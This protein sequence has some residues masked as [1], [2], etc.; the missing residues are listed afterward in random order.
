MPRTDEDS[1]LI[2]EATGEA[3]HVPK[4][5]KYETPDDLARKKYA[6]EKRKE[7]EEAHRLANELKNKT[8]GEFFWSLYDVGAAYHPEMSDG[9]L[10]KVIYLLTFLDYKRNILVSRQ[11][12]SDKYRPMTKDDVRNVIRL[13]RCKFPKFWDDLMSTGIIYEN[14]SGELEVDE[15]FRRGH[16]DKRELKDI[17]RIKLFTYAIRYMYENTDVR[18]HRYLAY[19]YRLIPYINLKYNVLCLN[20]LEVDKH[21]IKL[22]TARDLCELVGVEGRKDNEDRLINTLFKLMFISRDNR[23]LSVITLIK[24]YEDDVMCQ[25]ITINPQFYAGYISTED[26]ADIFDEFV[27]EKREGFDGVARLSV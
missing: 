1:V 21:R 3:I 15:S 22:L 23:K 26:M 5:T 27:I 14:E 19:L 9:M 24:R 13:H 7:Y 2:N 8:C 18:T 4:G 16:I 17:A 20:P 12:A 11:S 25:Y 6:M 10:V